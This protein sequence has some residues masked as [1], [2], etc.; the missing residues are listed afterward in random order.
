M[1]TEIQDLNEDPTTH[2]LPSTFRCPALPEWNVFLAGSGINR[3]STG[4]MNTSREMCISAFC[5]RDVLFLLLCY[6]CYCV[7]PVNIF[8]NPLL[9]RGTGA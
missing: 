5:H 2:V 7:I 4:P 8:N 3:L 6:F 1:F 9:L